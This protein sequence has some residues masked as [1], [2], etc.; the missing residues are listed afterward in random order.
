MSLSP[1]IRPVHGSG[2]AG[3][4]LDP[5]QTQPV[6]VKWRAEELNCQNLLIESILGEGECRLVRSLVGIYKN[7]TKICKNIAEIYKNV[8]GICIFSLKITRIWLDLAKSH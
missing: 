1:I 4:V 3:L 5:T 2:W 7:V 6:G 8:A